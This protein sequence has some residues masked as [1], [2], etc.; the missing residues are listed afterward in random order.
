MHCL[1]HTHT[2][3][4]TCTT[5]LPHGTALH[6]HA[7]LHIHSAPW[8]SLLPNST[9]VPGMHMHAHTYALA[10][11]R[12]PT[13]PRPPSLRGRSPG[14]STELSPPGRP[15]DAWPGAQ[16]LGR[17]PTA[18]AQSGASCLALPGARPAWEGPAG[19][20]RDLPGGS[21]PGPGTA[22]NPAWP[23]PWPGP[24]HAALLR[25]RPDFQGP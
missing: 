13:H 15:V 7:T 17:G 25:S 1:C 24:A 19:R 23:R 9:H 5:H 16:R 14:G 8:S 2:H 12:S 22:E 4:H 6:T 20:E 3:G 11:S 18:A 21:A 10:G